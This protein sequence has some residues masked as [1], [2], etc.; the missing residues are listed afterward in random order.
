MKNVKVQF[1]YFIYVQDHVMST[2]DNG[3]L[4]YGTWFNLYCNP[5][6]GILFEEGEEKEK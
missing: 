2:Y 1:T 6:M 3:C 4:M 5:L